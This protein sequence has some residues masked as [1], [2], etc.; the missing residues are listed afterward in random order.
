M[1]MRLFITMFFL[2]FAICSASAEQLVT[3]IKL[4]GFTVTLVKAD[5]FSYSYET[6]KAVEE[7]LKKNTLTLKAAKGK[8]SSDRTEV[9][10]NFVD[11]ESLE[12]ENCEL[13]Y[14]SVLSANKLSLKMDKNSIVSLK[15]NAQKFDA[16]I[17]D[18][19]Q[20][21]LEGNIVEASAK[22]K[23]GSVLNSQ[24]LT[25][26]KFKL[27]SSEK[28]MSTIHV[29]AS[30]ID[31]NLASASVLNVTGYAQKFKAKAQAQST[32]DALGVLN[33]EKAQIESKG[34]STIKVK[35]KH[36]KSKVSI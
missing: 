28:S 29:E 1:Y 8:N 36:L 9:T 3:K 7:E 30:E 17:K 10:I 35:A 12:L 25:G 34:G 21:N 11:L 24:A 14:T 5:E 22:L 16:D 23:K 31:F 32:V 33:V 4:S 18:G 19:S 20:L 27:S 2:T 15:L 6:A 26:K 13:V